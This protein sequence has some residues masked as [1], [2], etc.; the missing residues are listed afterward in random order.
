MLA[1]QTK[2]VFQSAYSL[3]D[4]DIWLFWQ[5]FGQSDKSG[6]SSSLVDGNILS[7]PKSSFELVLFILTLSFLYNGSASWGYLCYIR[8]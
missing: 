8:P 3:A 5:H 2:V 1:N 7:P 6:I 4:N